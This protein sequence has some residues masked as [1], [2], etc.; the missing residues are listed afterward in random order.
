MSNVTMAKEE[1]KEK[2]KT[3]EA[4]KVAKV[5]VSFT[6]TPEAHE[7]IIAKGGQPVALEDS[8]VLRFTPASE[9]AGNTNQPCAE[10]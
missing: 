9:E 3:T 7:S 1:I 4:E 6:L 8:A 5:L 10:I 2:T